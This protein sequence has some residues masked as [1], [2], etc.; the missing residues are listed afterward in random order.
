M[1]YWSN[2][3]LAKGLNHRSECSDGPGARQVGH[4][5]DGSVH[6][7]LGE[8]AESADVILGGASVDVGGEGVCGGIRR[9]EAIDFGI[10]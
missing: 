3:L 2:E 9:T 1:S 8:I 10:E 5:D 6:S 7:G 4:I